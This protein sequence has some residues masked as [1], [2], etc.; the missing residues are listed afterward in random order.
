[1]WTSYRIETKAKNEEKSLSAQFPADV[2]GY[3]VWNEEKSK[4]EFSKDKYIADLEEC[5]NQTAIE[6]S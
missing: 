1:M 4:Y 5:Y 2:R 3:A 6:R